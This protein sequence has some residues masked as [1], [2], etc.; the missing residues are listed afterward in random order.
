MAQRSGGK[1]SRVCGHPLSVATPFGSA[2]QIRK[3]LPLL[4]LLGYSRHVVGADVHLGVAEIHSMTE[5]T[6]DGNSDGNPGA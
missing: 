2:H 4:I 5:Y 6:N 1:Q 3:V